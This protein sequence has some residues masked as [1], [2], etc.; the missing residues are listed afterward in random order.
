MPAASLLG[1]RAPYNML[2]SIKNVNHYTSPIM[3]TGHFNHDLITLNRNE[4]SKF[5]TSSP[6][7]NNT[8]KIFTVFQSDPY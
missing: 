3:I 8:C 2:K 4:N 7:L 6:F 5:S 1:G